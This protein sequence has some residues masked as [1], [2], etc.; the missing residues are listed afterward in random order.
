MWALV[1]M[2]LQGRDWLCRPMTSDNALYVY[3]EKQYNVRK[4]ASVLDLDLNSDA[5]DLFASNM[6]KS[7]HPL[8]LNCLI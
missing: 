2:R 6:G 5:Y 4:R 3:S 7:L 1:V 8:S